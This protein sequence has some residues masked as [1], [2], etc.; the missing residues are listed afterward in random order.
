[1]DRLSALNAFVRTAEL[2]SFVAAG[3]ALGLTPSAVGKAVSRL[4]Q[5]LG[6]RLFQRSTRSIRLTDEGALFFERCRRILDDLDDAHA[7]LTQTQE[8]PRGV[9]RI[10]APN[11]SYHL[12]LPALPEFIQRYPEI[13][14]ELDFNDRM[15]DLIDERIDVA[16]RGGELSDSRLMARPLHSFQLL[17]CASPDYLERY[18]TPG[19]PQALEQHC[20]IR[21][22]FPNSGRMQHWPL[23]TPDD[24]HS[25]RM[26]HIITCNN[27]DALCSA[28]IGGLGIGCIPDFMV[29]EALADGTLCSLLGDYIEGPTRFSLIWPSN[30]HL[31]PKVRVFVDYLC[32]WFNSVN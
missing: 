21:F 18:G 25:L 2:G 8:V 4:E 3:R 29:A 19:N 16:I 10:S 1:M 27:V 12:L 32:E 28:T 20:A 13:E 15:V 17:L 14:L 6:V 30:R 7:A 22:R 5:Q 24:E 11:V 9:L 23:K 26:K 31:P